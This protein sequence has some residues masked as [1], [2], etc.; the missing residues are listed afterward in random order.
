MNVLDDRAQPK[1]QGLMQQNSRVL[2]LGGVRP[3][4]H[5]HG[6][7]QQLERFQL[8]QRGPYNHSGRW[9]DSRRRRKAS[10]R[11][12]SRRASPSIEFVRQERGH[13]QFQSGRSQRNVSAQIYRQATGTVSDDG[14]GGGNTVCL[15]K[16]GNYQSHRIV[17]L[18]AA[19]NIV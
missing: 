4:Q 11:R 10:S 9:P 14:Y 8:H 3:N 5:A 1:Q 15:P 6:H 17:S 12:K 7:C 13:F 16:A 19:G 2:V 18:P